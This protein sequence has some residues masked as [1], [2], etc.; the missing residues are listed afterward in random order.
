MLIPK[1]PVTN[2]K[3]ICSTIQSPY[4]KSLVSCLQNI[5][6]LET[7]NIVKNELATKFIVYKVIMPCFI[8]KFLMPRF[9]AS[10][11][12]ITCCRGIF[13]KIWQRAE[14]A[15]IQKF[16]AFFFIQQNII[17]KKLNS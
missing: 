15:D 8:E 12:K 5:C 1:I 11:L 14:R 13:L 6:Q 4:T 17:V 7:I 10:C 2:V 3:I 9:S 16:L